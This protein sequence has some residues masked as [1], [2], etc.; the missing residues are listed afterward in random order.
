MSPEEKIESAEVKCYSGS[1]YG[2]RPCSFRWREREYEVK[3]ILHTWYSVAANVPGRRRRHFRLRT[4]E[5]TIVELSYDEDDDL[6][7]IQKMNDCS[8]AV[9]SNED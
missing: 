8:I 1:R 5:G 4:E 9:G 3:E 7:L 6:W 2:E